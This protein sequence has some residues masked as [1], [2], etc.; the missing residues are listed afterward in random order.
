MA[1]LKSWKRDLGLMAL[2]YALVLFLYRD[3]ALFG[4][5]FISADTISQGA[6]FTKYGFDQLKT[7][8]FPL[9][10]PHIFSGMPF[11]ASM[12]FDHVV[13]PIRFILDRLD[14]VG[15]YFLHSKITHFYLG[16]LF[17]YLLMRSYKLNR[18][19]AFIAATV[20]V[21]SPMV[22]SLEHG[23]RIITVMYIPVVFY[24]VKRLYERRDLSS[25]AWAGLAVGFQMMGNHLQ[26]VYYTWL[27]LGLYFLSRA[28]AD[29][30]RKEGYGLT[31]RGGAL[32]CAGLIIGV[33]VA[34]FLLLSIYE[35]APFSTRGSGD[36]VAAYNFAT[37]WSLHPQE[38]LTFLIPSFMG[39]GGQTYWGYMPFTHCPNYLGV[40]ALFLVGGL[41]GHGTL[42]WIVLLLG[43][44]SAGVYN[45]LVCDY[46]AEKIGESW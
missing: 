8:R 36:P 38:M 44:L 7:H 33:G 41:R 22:A 1:V 23:N 17:T 13:Y 16:G 24:L 11:F 29:L 39:F 14:Q 19:S 40:V 31:L 35:Y 26:I 34:A 28:L 46:Q 15:L 3:V 42:T 20:F 9:W 27:F 2:L 5:M 43:F 37:N 10:Y 4:K 6:V 25:L 21:F 18:S 12:S 32:M 45:F 30:R